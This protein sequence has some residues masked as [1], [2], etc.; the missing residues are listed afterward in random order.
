MASPLTTMELMT[1]KLLLAPSTTDKTANQAVQRTSEQQARN[2]MSENKA[3]GWRKK[4]HT[5]PPPL[6]LGVDGAAGADDSNDRRR[7]HAWRKTIQV[8]RPGTPISGPPATD[9]AEDTQGERAP[10]STPRRDT[11]PKLNR[12]TSLFSGFKDAPKG[13]NFNEPW[14]DEQPI[15]EPYVDPQL[16]I[17]S[18]RSHMI[19]FSMKPIPLEHNN[20]LFC[21]FEA[22]HKLRD[23]KERLDVALQETQQNLQRAE[24]QWTNEHTLYAE[25]IRRLELLI[26]QGTT[27]V[28][29]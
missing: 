21:I 2:A 9:E 26:A 15:Y 11:K 4:I 23:E 14:S 16:A 6:K 27:G 8:S 22:Y 13:P 24:H 12:Y 17:Q 7:H 1:H 3:T 18:I 28:A 29:G 5:K 19:N 25:E 10:S 20:H